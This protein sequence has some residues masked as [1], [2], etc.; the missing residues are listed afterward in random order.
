MLM[1]RIP[2]RVPVLQ[3][4]RLHGPEAKEEKKKKTAPKSA[5]SLAASLTEE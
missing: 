1:T 5:T 2:V 4:G 3:L